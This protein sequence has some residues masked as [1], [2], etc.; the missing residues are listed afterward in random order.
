MP[1]GGELLGVGLALHPEP[2]FL[3]VAREAIEAADFYELSPE[4]HWRDD[5]RPAESRAQLLDRTCS[6][7]SEPLTRVLDE[8]P[9]ALVHQDANDHNVLVEGDGSTA[10]VTGLIDFGDAL[11][12][13]RAAE[14]AVAAA[15]A[16]FGRSD[17]VAAIASLVAG[18][19]GVATLEELELDYVFYPIGIAVYMIGS[20]IG[21]INK[22]DFPQPEIAYHSYCCT[23]TSLC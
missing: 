21:I 18:Y 11:T 15:Y 19:D 3:L 1:S 17:P 6:S 12:T 20:N 4:L 2:E 14:P 16:C 23:S 8:L 5:E 7:L 10:R 22:I 13:I 9:R